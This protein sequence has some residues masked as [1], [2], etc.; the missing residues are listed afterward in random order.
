MHIGKVGGHAITL[1]LMNRFCL[2]D[3]YNG[4]PEQFDQISPQELAGKRLITG[5]FSYCHT[6]KLPAKRFLF[7]M[8]REP[9][10][11]VVSNYWYLRTYQGEETP[12]NIDMV[13]LAKAYDLADFIELDN[14]QVRQVVENHQ[15]MFFA[16]DWRSDNRASEKYLTAAMRHLADFD[17]IGLH[18][19]YDESMQLLS[20][21]RGWLPWP[22]KN[23]LNVTPRRDTLTSLPSDTVERLKQLNDLDLRLYEE[24]KRCFLEQRAEMLKSLVRTNSLGQIVT[25]GAIASPPAAAE[26]FADKPFVGEGWHTRTILSGRYCRWIGPGTEATVYTAIERLFGAKLIL[27]VCGWVSSAALEGLSVKANGIPCKRIRFDVQQDGGPDR[28]IAALHFDLPASNANVLELGLT[29]VKPVA[30]AEMGFPDDQGRHGA[31]AIS[32]IRV[33]GSR[34]ARLLNKMK[35]RV[36]LWIG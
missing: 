29:S 21:S 5:H 11:R 28:Q 20:A 27:E 2:N 3:C 25:D 8:A 30:L 34:K 9:L 16:G 24:I 10:D 6:L 19:H 22:S 23:R 31:V 26:V 15:C 35:E 12:T 13:R 14:L 17:F 7:S 33:L 1:E 36:R 32:A 18:E 4:S